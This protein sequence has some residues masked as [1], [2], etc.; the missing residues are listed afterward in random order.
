MAGSEPEVEHP[1]AEA[2]HEET[3]PRVEIRTWTTA[4][5]ATL[6]ARLVSV[7]QNNVLLEK[8]GGGQITIKLSSLSIPDTRYLRSIG[9]IQ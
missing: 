8:K 6:E 7:E 9:V 2:L 3:A 5:G 1:P 4:D